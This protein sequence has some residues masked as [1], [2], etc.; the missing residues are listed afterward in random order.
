MFL[1]GMLFLLLSSHLSHSLSLCMCVCVCA[2]LLTGANL[3]M[4]HL[5]VSNY[6]GKSAVIKC[7][8]HGY[9]GYGKYFCRDPC[10]EHDITVRTKAGQLTARRGRFTLQDNHSAGIFWV[11]V[12]ELTLT[13]SG[14]YWCGITITGLDSYSEV[15]LTALRGE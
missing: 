15:H 12:N 14:K 10:S 6:V 8:A 2:C 1:C 7:P 5:K 3:V 9:A 4:S 13:D 11:T